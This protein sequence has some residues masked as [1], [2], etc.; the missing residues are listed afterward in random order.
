MDLRG[1]D[2]AGQGY[3]LEVHVG[4]AW[5]SGVH[6]R[7]R[8][9]QEVLDDDLLHVAM[10]PVGCG[11]RLKCLDAVTTVFPDSYED[12]RREGDGQATG[13]FEGLQAAARL[14]V[15]CAPMAVQVRS[16]RLQHHSLGGGDPAHCR[17]LVDVQGAGIGVGEQARLVQ[18]QLGHLGQQ[19][20]G[21][22]VSVA[23]QPVGG[24]RVTQ[25]RTLAECEEGLVAAGGGS[26]PGDV[27][28]LLGGEV[29]GL[30]AGRRLG[31]R[32]VTAAVPTEH[33]ERYEHFGA[34]GDPG[35]VV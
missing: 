21:R 18:H 22:G 28:D 6:C 25:F 12:P 4:R 30:Q 7:T 24:D 2:Q 31:E 1:E 23:F 15:R 17:E 10:A 16:E 26:S 32:A 8:L 33:G 9:G 19:V 13:G 14:L 29:G 27:E 5:G 20:H 11:D 35:S 3:G 34:V